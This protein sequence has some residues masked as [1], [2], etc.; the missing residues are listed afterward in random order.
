MT[1]CLT[2]AT[3][4]IGSAVARALLARGHTVR[5]TVR[6]G[7]DLS[8]LAGLPLE[9][10]I[11]DLDQP[12]TLAQ[13]LEGCNTLYHIAADYRLWVPKPEQIYRT[14]VDGTVAL[15]QAA[16]G[17]GVERVVYTSSV[18]TLGLHP[19]RRPADERTAVSIDDMIGHYKRSKFLAEQQVLKMVREQALPAVIVNPSA[20]VGPRDIKPTPTGQI[21][22]DAAT[23]RM[24][25]YV[26]TG[27][28]IVHVEDCAQ[29]HLLA[30][31]RGEVGEKYILGGTDMSL[32]QI[33]DMVCELAGRKQSLVRIPHAISMGA[34]VLSEGMARLTG[35]PPR[36]T[37][38]GARLAKK[39]M[40]FSSAKAQAELGYTARPAEHAFADAL[41]W[42]KQHRRLGT[43]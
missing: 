29:G 17:A 9:Q 42:F 18:A 19:D 28:N 21:V 38:D 13:A 12:H 8:N 32:K 20:P 16:I 40:Y 41:A 25:A 24:P 10:V 1:V 22:I 5:A 36:V 34:A 4:F 31:E 27:L 2:G 33:I 11:A 39:Y 15:M 37:L 26:D 23:G 43:R 7:S 3:G 30:A 14:N 35:R 6:A